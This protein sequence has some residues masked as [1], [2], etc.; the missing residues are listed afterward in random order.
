MIRGDPVQCYFF[1]QTIRVS[2]SHLQKQ[3]GCGGANLTTGVTSLGQKLRLRTERKI[4]SIR[5]LQI[6]QVPVR[7]RV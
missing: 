2:K 3:V 5:C 4:V 6:R 1:P 7:V